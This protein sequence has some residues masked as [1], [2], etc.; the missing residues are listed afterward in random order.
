LSL[1]AQLVDNESSKYSDGTYN[2]NDMTMLFINASNWILGIVGSLTL[3]MFIY[4]GVLFLIS[5][6]SSEQISKA[7]G[8]LVA[9]VIGLTIV[10]SSYLIIKFA[11]ASI[12]INWNGGSV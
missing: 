12:G 11:L 10:F 3:I 2:L 4:G 7:K 9:A 1:Q 5:S 8:V 6:G